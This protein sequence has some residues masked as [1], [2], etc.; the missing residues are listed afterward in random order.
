MML[1]AYLDAS[2]SQSALEEQYMSAV[3]NGAAASRMSTISQAVRSR[4]FQ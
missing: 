3:G 4:Y 2:V 1:K